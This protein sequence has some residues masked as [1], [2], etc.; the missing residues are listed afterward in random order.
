MLLVSLFGEQTITN[1]ATG[2]QARAARGNA[3]VALLVA[4]AVS[5]Q[6]GGLAIPGVGRQPGRRDALG[7]AAC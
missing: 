5:P 2:V 1:D 7:W 6:A 4:R 3:L